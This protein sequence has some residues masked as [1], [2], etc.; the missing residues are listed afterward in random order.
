MLAIE[1]IFMKLSST[2][3]SVNGIDFGM[4]NLSEAKRTYIINYFLGN[5]LERMETLQYSNIDKI[6]KK[7]KQFVDLFLNYNN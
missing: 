6:S 1:I 5:I 4:S 7:S 3:N 2:S